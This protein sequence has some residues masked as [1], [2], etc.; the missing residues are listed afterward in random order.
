[1]S[2]DQDQKGTHT[3]LA[4]ETL[5]RSPRSPILPAK[6]A[7]NMMFVPW[8]PRIHLTTGHPETRPSPEGTR[9]GDIF[10]CSCVF[11]FEQG[12]APANQTKER[13]KTKSS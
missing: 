8:A 12:V 9:Q 5:V 2:V 6:H 11:F 7:G 10:L 13:A 4:H 1:M 3:R